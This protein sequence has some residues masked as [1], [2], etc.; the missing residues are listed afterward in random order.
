MDKE[1]L[2]YSDKYDS[3]M[4]SIL[5]QNDENSLE[6][7]LFSCLNNCL[8]GNGR[9]LRRKQMLLFTPLN[10]CENIH[11]K[12]LPQFLRPQAATHQAPGNTKKE[13]W[14]IVLAEYHYKVEYHKGK[15]NTRYVVQI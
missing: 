12:Q 10:S 4:D 2:M 1:Y 14:T 11:K 13:R 3:S 8:Q 7:P 5:C 15:L 9:P 6:K